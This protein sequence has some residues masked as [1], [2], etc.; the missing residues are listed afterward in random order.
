MHK[1]VLYNW[2]IQSRAGD[3]AQ[4]GTVEKGEP[5]GVKKDDKILK[6]KRLIFYA[7]DVEK[8]K[9]HVGLSNEA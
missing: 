4:T 3:M 9:A 6:D 2:E 7:E 8:I 1:G 5:V